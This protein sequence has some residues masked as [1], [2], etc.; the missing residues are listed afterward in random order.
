MLN[1]IFGIVALGW[2]LCNDSMMM[3][4]PGLMQAIGRQ[5][6]DT[7][8]MLEEQQKRRIESLKEQEAAA[9]TQAE[10]DRLRKEQADLRARRVV[11]TSSAANDML[12]KMKVDDP[13]FFAHYGTAL[14]T[15]L[16]LN[17][18]MIV[19]GVG[20][21]RLRPWGRTV[22]LWVAALH[23][24]R[25]VA[26]TASM[27]VIVGPIWGRMTES[28]TSATG[29]VGMDPE[30]IR[31]MSEMNRTV[32]V[33]WQ[34]GMFVLGS[35]Y[36]IVT[37]WLLNTRSSLAALG[38]AKPDEPLPAD[39][40]PELA[41]GPMAA[42]VGPSKLAGVLPDPRGPRRIGIF[43]IIIALAL[44]LTCNLPHMIFAAFLPTFSRMT[45]SMEKATAKAIDDARKQELEQARAKVEA[46]KTDAERDAAKAAL[47]ELEASPKSPT[48]PMS[49]FYD[50]M[51][52]RRVRP[53]VWLD[54]AT[55]LVLNVAMFVGAI[56]LVQVRE[57]GRKTSVWVAFFK[58]VR[59]GVALALGV[60]VVMP[61]LGQAMADNLGRF[62]AQLPTGPRGGPNIAD[63]RK[64][65]T[66]GFTASL[67]VFE[68]LALIWPLIVLWV[69]SRPKAQAACLA[70]GRNRSGLP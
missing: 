42:E 70:S 23:L 11:V 47:Q 45:Q 53:Y 32:S 30:T 13:R 28:M 3:A 39:E 1:I 9:K 25:L 2:G 58:V 63:L 50:S 15:G 31:G 4:Y 48:P 22:S 40:W 66:I 34:V 20:L 21:L 41:P 18:A 57:W 59:I 52:D 38:L 46:A 51:N 26:V 33:A 16:I 69:L 65:M 12:T 54:A 37:L 60:G 62:L 36:P 17:T 49:M 67:V 14:A 56:G 44:L 55:G 29:G 43:G 35:I 6:T 7:Q 68:L 64:G 5:S 24:V 61:A 19:A 27:V 10:K 8:R